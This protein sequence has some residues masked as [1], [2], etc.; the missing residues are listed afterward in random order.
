[1]L[2]ANSWAN[3]PQY[4]HGYL[5]PLFSIALLWMRRE[6]LDLEQVRPNAWGLALIAFAA[7]FR[8]AGA[9]F[10]FEWFDFLSL[11]P[12]VFGICLLLG[13]M[14]AVRWAWPAIGFLIFMIPLPHT[15]E[16]A[17]RG[18]L[19]R[20]GTLSSTYI[21][22]TIGL[23]AI[24][25]GNVILVNEARIG[26]VEA[27]SGLRMLVIFFALSTAVALLSERPLW[28]R[29]LIVISA[30]PIA[31]I[32]NITRITVTGI[33]HVTVSSKLADVVFHDLAGWLMIPLA[34]CLLWLELW[35]LSQLLIAQDTRPVVAGVQI[36]G[37]PTAAGPN[38]ANQRSSSDS[39]S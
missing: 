7:M 5:V 10:F 24:S 22:Q 31:L 17:M 3:D 34:L 29:I 2:M 9:Y 21:M 8:L 11:I 19:R 16:L 12:F 33:L 39:K 18:P 23:P 36:P 26:V 1:M 28:E 37:V 25:E 20:L 13:G 32:S 15:L 30:V 38:V 35:F 6:M 14:H 27:C 4:S